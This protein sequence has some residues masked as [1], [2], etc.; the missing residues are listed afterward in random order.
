MVFDYLNV[1]LFSSAPEKLRESI[2]GNCLALTSSR[3]PLAA[4]APSG[5]TECY[6]AKDVLDHDRHAPGSYYYFE[7]PNGGTCF[8]IELTL[9]QIEDIE[10]KYSPTLSFAI[11]RRPLLASLSS[12][13]ILGRILRSQGAHR[14]RRLRGLFHD[15]SRLADMRNHLDELRSLYTRLLNLPE[16]EEVRGAGDLLDYAYA[17]PDWGTEVP[18]DGCMLFGKANFSNFPGADDE[19]VVHWKSSFSDSR[20]VFTTPIITF[21]DLCIAAV[22]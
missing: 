18:L 14:V 13:S 1:R 8:E 17:I 22:D 3:H 20:M 4:V 11:R 7:I 16:C 10:I 15:E 6:S 12:T 2:V 19:L 5:S 9:T 21:R